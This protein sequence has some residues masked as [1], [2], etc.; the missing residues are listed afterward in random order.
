MAKL[1][2]TEGVEIAD[3]SPPAGALFVGR[4]R[5]LGELRAALDSALDSRGGLVLIAGEAG[6]GKTRLVEEL[7]RD[8]APQD[9]RAVWGHCW[10]G[11]RAPAFWPGTQL[12]RAYAHRA[13][14][15]LL[16]APLGG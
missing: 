8:A 1:A 9:A 7:A 13:E 5:E 12:V 16:R 6:I 4:E 15:A 10:A 11:A 14:R 2:I 3:R